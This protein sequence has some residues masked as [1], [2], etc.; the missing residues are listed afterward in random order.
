LPENEKELACFSTFTNLI[1]R[2]TCFFDD[3]FPNTVRAEIELDARISQINDLDRF[4]I[5]ISG[6]KNP[7][8]TETTSTMQI[9]IVDMNYVPINSKLSNILVTTN[10]AY[11][12]RRA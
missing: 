12:V 8:S 4:S 9:R 6:I 1:D 3:T 10:N 5:E 7:I 11:T 2:V